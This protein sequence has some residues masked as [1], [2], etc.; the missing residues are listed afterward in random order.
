MELAPNLNSSGCAVNAGPEK[1]GPG[2]RSHLTMLC[3]RTVITLRAS[4]AAAQYIVIG[5]VCGC[6]CVY[7]ALLPR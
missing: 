4:E 7:V 3:I 6:V 5:P 2:I 1:E